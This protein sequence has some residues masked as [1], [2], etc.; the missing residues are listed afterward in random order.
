MTHW[1]VIKL[2][3]GEYSCEILAN[4]GAA[5][6]S[7]QFREKEFIDG[8]LNP[9]ETIAQKYKGVILAP[10]PN[11]VA[12]AK[13]SF[14]K[15]AYTL[16]IN[17]EKEGLALHG[18]LYDK[19]FEVIQGSQHKVKL[20]YNYK[21][22][23]AGF[24]FCFTLN[25]SYTLN[26]DGSLLVKSEVENKGEQMPFGLGWHPYF[27]MSQSIDECVLQMPAAKKLRLDKA[28]I[29]TGEL[30]PFT[31]ERESLMLVEHHFDDCFELSQN[32]DGII[33]LIDAKFS[34]EIKGV[35]LN[36]F[37]YFQ[38][39]TPKNRSS[40]ALEPM[41]CAPNAFNNQMGLIILEPNEKRSY[42]YQ[43]KAAYAN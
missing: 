28:L 24:P 13:Y 15:K 22:T 43:L 10:F 32:G 35:N 1:Q 41:T 26:N 25:V 8:Y 16:A 23:E 14:Q 27:T 2:Q 4:Y 3:R 40:I 17:R 31:S 11:R 30:L 6:N 38:I 7:Y 33:R 5:L 42:A 20:S 39:Y 19:P 37:P 34:L 21:G 36:E 12:K 29:P 18:L 9:Q